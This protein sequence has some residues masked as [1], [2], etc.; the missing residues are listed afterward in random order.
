MGGRV[1]PGPVDGIP[2]HLSHG[3]DLSLTDE[4]PPPELVR[5]PTLVVGTKADLIDY[6]IEQIPR[7]VRGQ[8]TE[9]AKRFQGCG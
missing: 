3:A 7:Y 5:R 9:L 8:M 6:Y 2:H 1:E 4:V